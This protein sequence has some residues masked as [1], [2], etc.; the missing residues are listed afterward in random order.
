MDDYHKDVIISNVYEDLMTQDLLDQNPLDQFLQTQKRLPSKERA[1]FMALR[2]SVMSYYTVLDVNPGESVIV[3]DIL[4]ELSPQT[5]LEESGTRAM[6]KGMIF[7]ARVIC[8]N[9]QFYFTGSLMPDI[10]ERSVFLAKETIDFSLKN[11]AFLKDNNFTKNT[12]IQTIKEEILKMMP[13]TFSWMY[14][15]TVFE[16]M[17]NPE[18]T[19]LSNNDGELI[20]TCHTA[21]TINPQNRHMI[22]D[23]LNKHPNL[24][25]IIDDRKWCWVG[26][27]V[28]DIEEEAKNVKI[29]DNASLA[30]LIFLIGPDGEHYLSKGDI[31]LKKKELV[32]ETLSKERNSEGELM[33]EA[34][35]GNLATYKGS[36]FKKINKGAKK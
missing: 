21:F 26:D 30:H 32:L 28:N 29:H 12:P 23:R 5:V 7:G 3:Q 10:D 2:H 16:R 14:L 24:I 22:I 25:C 15:D 19:I 11:K 34:L 27:E 17:S 9:D 36:T 13:A 8:V 18:E 35:L 31:Y 33:I 4:R 6:K 20:V 1:Y